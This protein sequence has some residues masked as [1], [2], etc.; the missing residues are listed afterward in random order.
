MLDPA[1]A[2]GVGVAVDVS[3]TLIILFTIFGAFLQH[4]GAG[5]F[6]IDFSFSA[7]GG[8]PTGAGRTVVLGLEPVD[9][10]L[11]LL[12]LGITLLT[13]GSGRTNILLGAVHLLLF[14]T[15]LALIL[16]R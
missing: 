9:M 2:G 3:A 13:Y 4:S 8:K 11:L 12:T 16:D 7:M 1:G 10:L 14:F 15:Y 5:K 6:Y